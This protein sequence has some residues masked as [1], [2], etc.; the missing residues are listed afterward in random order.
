MREC[1]NRGWGGV[2]SSEAVESEQLEGEMYH[3]CAMA[4][5]WPNPHLRSGWS[6]IGSL[7]YHHSKLLKFLNS[8]ANAGNVDS[9][10]RQFC[11]LAAANCAVEFT[12]EVDR[13]ALVATVLDPRFRTVNFLSAAEGGKCKDALSTAYGVLD[14]KERDD[15]PVVEEPKTKRR[16]GEANDFNFDIDDSPSPGK[17][18]VTNEPQRYLALPDESRDTKPLEWWKAHAVSYPLLSRLARRYLAIPASSASSERLFS[19]LKLTATAARQNLKPDVLCMLL[20]IAVQQN[21]QL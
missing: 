17:L 8:A 2:R 19:R 18:A 6:R 9:R 20:F 5:W 10:I 14:S 1:G 16:R 7:M 11:Q 4:T 12:A 3:R 21:S 13:P 15:A